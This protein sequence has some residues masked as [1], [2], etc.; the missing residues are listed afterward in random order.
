MS[1]TAEIGEVLER[2]RSVAIDY[3]RLTGKPLCITGG[4]AKYISVS[5]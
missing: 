2:A 5:T 3:Y 1:R 4:I